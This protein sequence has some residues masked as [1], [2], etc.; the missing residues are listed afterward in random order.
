M[1]ALRQAYSLSSIWMSRKG[2]TNS[3]KILVAT[4]AISS[5]GQ[6]IG[7]MKSFPGETRETRHQ[8]FCFGS[9]DKVSPRSYPKACCQ[10]VPVPMCSRFP[11]CSLILRFTIEKQA[12]DFILWSLIISFAHVGAPTLYTKP[13]PR[14]ALVYPLLYLAS[15][16]KWCCIFIFSVFFFKQSSPS[17]FSLISGF[18]GQY[19][20]F[21]KNNPACVFGGRELHEKEIPVCTIIFDRPF[22]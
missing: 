4:R 14:S 3:S 5:S 21:T 17:L 7:M 10:T 6:C 2:F 18:Q 16:C 20:H 19:S 22:C 13:A 8:I 9:A 15:V 11:V 1:M 12:M